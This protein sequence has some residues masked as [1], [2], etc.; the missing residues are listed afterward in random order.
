M[1]IFSKH[2]GRLALV[3]A[4]SVGSLTVA[5][6]DSAEDRLAGYVESGDQLSS[7]GEFDKATIEYR[8]ALAIDAN[9]VPAHLG[10]AAIYEQRANYPAMMAHLNK[11]LEVEAKNVTALVKLGQLL[12]LSGKLEDAQGNADTALGVEPDNVAALVLKAGVALRLG[13]AEIALTNAKKAIELDPANPTA[14][15]VLIGER[16]KEEDFAGALAIADDITARAPDDFG[17]ALVKLQ[18]IEQSGDQDGAGEYL[19]KMVDQFRIS[20]RCARLSPAGISAR[21][22]CLLPKPSFVPSPRPNR[23]TMVPPWRL[24]SSF[25]RAAARKPPLK[26]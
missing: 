25:S 20:I 12:M 5:A 21:K 26:S 16:L 1:S 13:N 3:A 14:H 6:C 19:K 11:V 4:L 2:A 10:I 15:A 9:S 7:E 8:N 24:S 17:V 23:M 18:V 22:I